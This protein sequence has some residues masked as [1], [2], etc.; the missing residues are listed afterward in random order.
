MRRRCFNPK[1]SS[2]DLY[3]GRGIEVCPQWAESYDQFVEDMGLKPKGMTL[4]RL[5]TNGNYEPGNCAWVSVRDNINNRRKT[6]TINGVPLTVVAEKT[7]IKADTLRKRLSSLN[8]GA[9]RI[10]KPRLNDAKP[11][12]HGTRSRYERDR[13]RCD[14]CKAFNAERA[15]LRRASARPV[16]PV[17]G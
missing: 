2:W 11:A 10:L 7:G 6:L 4:E 13:C 14:K 1:D 5:N 8:V 15:R 3:G 17:P 12:D 16:D 9:D